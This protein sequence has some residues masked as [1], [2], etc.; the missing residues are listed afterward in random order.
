MSCLADFAGLPLA[1]LTA[2]IDRMHGKPSPLVAAPALSPA[3]H[4]DGVAASTL[5]EPTTCC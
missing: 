5:L 4:P 2:E 3:N 1:E